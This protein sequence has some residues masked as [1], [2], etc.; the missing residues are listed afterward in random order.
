MKK[1]FAL[2]LAAVM[3]A[4]MTTVAF[5]DSVE[6]NSVEFGGASTRL[7]K[8]DSDDNVGKYVAD[9]TT[10]LEPGETYYLS[11]EINGVESYL[12]EDGDMDIDAKD[13]NKYKVYADWKYGEIVDLEVAYKKIQTWDST[14]GYAA[15]DDYRYVVMFT[16][17]DDTTANAF[18]DVAGTVKVGTSS[19]KA[20]K[21]TG[22]DLDATITKDYI[23]PFDG[24]FGSYTDGAV[25]KFES[26]LGEIDIDF[27]D[28]AMFTVNVTGQG[29]LNL[30]WNTDFDSEI[31]A[32]D[33]SA[34]MDFVTFEGEP[35][36]NKNGTMYIYADA[37]TFLYQVV[38]GKLAAVDAEYDEDY[39]A[40]TFKTRSLGEYVISDKEID[41]DAVNT[42]VD[43]KDDASSTTDGGTTNPDT[44]R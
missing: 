13:M 25:V 9:D 20:D 44:G 26:D 42:E 32:L 10:V 22:F 27:E 38:D 41:L 7:F 28:V 1:I 37:D 19:S 40:W 34:N 35:S 16:T 14:D 15:G 39:E 23:N 8:Y 3:T 5:A 12:K 36:F 21:T 2:A 43:D 24:D 4:G 29:K 6:I 18:I 11:L 33:K 31:A 30:M 17:P